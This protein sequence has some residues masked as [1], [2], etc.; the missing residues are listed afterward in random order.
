MRARLERIR[1]GLRRPTDVRR[2]DLDPAERE[3]LRR[4]GYVAD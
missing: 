2:Q 4:L 3:R 1:A